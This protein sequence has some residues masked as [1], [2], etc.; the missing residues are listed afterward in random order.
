MRLYIIR[1]ADPDYPNNTITA[2]G[3]EEA[4]SLARRL[5][6]YDLTHIYSSP[7][8]RAQETAQYTADLA[9][10]EPVIMDWL[11]ERGDWRIDLLD[12]DGTPQTY[13]AW[14]LHGEMVRSD[15]PLP[16]HDHW[17]ENPHVPMPRSRQ[18]FEDITVSSDAFIAQHGYAREG[19]RYRI[20]RANQDQ[21]AVFCHNGLA[22]TWLAHLL[23]IPLTLMWIGFWLAPSS[24]TTVVFDE[25][26]DQWA[27]PRCLCLGD[28]SHLY[29]DRLPV[30]PRGIKGTFR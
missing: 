22:L 4:R 30:R 25:R 2:A 14:D 7:L 9:G 20:K 10:I 15:E 18:E 29:A 12:R 8:N 17:H 28:T 16:T 13:V 11:Y 3:H 1:H 26:S 23:E 27:V 6:R 24:V 19:T 5:A 21:I